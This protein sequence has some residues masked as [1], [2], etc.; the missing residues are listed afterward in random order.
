MWVFGFYWPFRGWR[1]RYPWPVIAISRV[2][3]ERVY[4]IS[5]LSRTLSLAVT[6]SW[7]VHPVSSFFLQTVSRLQ[8]THPDPKRPEHSFLQTVTRL[9]LPS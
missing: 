7:G 3:L 8:L 1:E 2:L 4:F 6:A 5:S 9:Q